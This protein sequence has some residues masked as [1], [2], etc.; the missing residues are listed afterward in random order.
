MAGRGGAA[1]GQFGARELAGQRISFHVGLPTVDW[2]V[3][4]LE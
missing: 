4:A 1:G 3:G 2:G